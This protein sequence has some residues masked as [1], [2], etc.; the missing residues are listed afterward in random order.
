MAIR[1]VLADESD[2]L[3][4]GAQTVIHETHRLQVVAV[5]RSLEALLESLQVS[6]PDV[7]VMSESLHHD[8]VLSV[9]ERVLWR[10]PLARV[11]LLGGMADGLLVRDVLAGGVRGYLYRADDLCQELPLA[12]ETV[13]RGRPYLSHTASAE[14]LTA[15]QQPHGRERLD[16]E[17]RQVLYLLAHGAHAGQISEQLGIDKRRVYWIRE[18]LRK[19]FGARTNEHLIQRAAAEGFIPRRD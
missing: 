1:V 8:E 9:V 12:I 18:K 3:L 7:V 13:M 5:V 14:Y 19:R 16:R 15:T 2:L 4:S 17:A 10:W 11:I 6:A